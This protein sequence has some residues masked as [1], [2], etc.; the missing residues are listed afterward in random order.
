MGLYRDD[1]VADSVG[2]D[3]AYAEWILGCAALAFEGCGIGSGAR[4]A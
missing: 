3:E 2:G 4:E 1:F